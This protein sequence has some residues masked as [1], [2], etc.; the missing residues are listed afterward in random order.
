MLEQG[1]VKMSCRHSAAMGETACLKKK[2]K[3]WQMRGHIAKQNLGPGF[4]WLMPLPPYSKVVPSFQK[5]LS[6]QGTRIYAPCQPGPMDP[7]QEPILCLS[8]LLYCSD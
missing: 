1:T 6:L 2:K 3:W 5:L 4:S 7:P 8:F